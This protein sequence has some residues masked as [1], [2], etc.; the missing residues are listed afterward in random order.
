M[1]AAC[2]LGC[3]G[4][5]FGAVGGVLG[6]Y[7]GSIAGVI[8]LLFLFLPQQFQTH[9]TVMATPRI[10]LGIHPTYHVVETTWQ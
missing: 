8:V 5:L 7:P 2:S 1:A 4:T 9:V 6:C 10:W 3:F